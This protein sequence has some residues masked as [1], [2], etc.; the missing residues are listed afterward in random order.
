MRLR[1]MDANRVRLELLRH[2]LMDLLAVVNTDALEK[3]RE[4]EKD[5]DDYWLLWANWE[6]DY[7]ATNTALNRV[8]RLLDELRP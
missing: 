2:D 4:A 7:D 8:N 6:R 5:T 1:D 3:L